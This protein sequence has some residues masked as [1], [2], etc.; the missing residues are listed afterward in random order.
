MPKPKAVIGK[1]LRA[2]T[3]TQAREL[4]KAATTSV[5]HL[6]HVAAGRRGVSAEFAQ[7]LA[8][9]SRTL[10]SKALLLDQ[11][12]LCEACGVCPIVD[13]RKHQVAA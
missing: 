4:A 6:R 13:K 8:H 2:A 10:H 9:A 5:P 3:P 1:W 11:R 7:R 12:L